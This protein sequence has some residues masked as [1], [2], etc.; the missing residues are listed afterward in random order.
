MIKVI[1]VKNK[2]E[3]NLKAH[4]LLKKIVD[5]KTLLGLS[6]GTTPDYQKMIMEPGDVLPGAVFIVDD[7]WT[8]D[9]D[10]SNLEAMKKIGLNKYLAN[11][12]IDFYGIPLKSD[13]DDCECEDEE[14]CDDC[15]CEDC[16]CSL[17]VSAVVEGYENL[18]GDLYAKYPKKVAVMGIGS[19]VHT[20][21][22]F[23]NSEASKS[24]Q[25]V[26]YDKVEDE[27]PERITTTFKALEKFD[28]FVILAFGED[29]KE[30]LR[31]VMDKEE[32]DMQKYPAVFYR[33]T[34]SDCYLVTDQKI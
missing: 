28:T 15:D 17:D 24:K 31:I 4:E 13:C 8:E 7:R 33:K 12:K 23:P 5:K 14:N 27:Y 29:K 26:V 9:P 32:N 21:G 3:G 2:A 30:A 18:L 6:G 19:N 34:K 10:G 11:A 20:S 16:E 1:T 22:I 25:L